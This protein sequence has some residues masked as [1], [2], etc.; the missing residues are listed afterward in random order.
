MAEDVKIVDPD[1]NWEIEGR[2][3]SISAHGA[4]LGH[5]SFVYEDAVSTKGFRKVLKEFRD[6]A[7]QEDE[8]TQDYN[9]QRAEYVRQARDAWRAANPGM[10][11]QN[12]LRTFA[13][14]GLAASRAE[15][16]V[17][18]RTPNYRDWPGVAQ[19]DPR[20]PVQAL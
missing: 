11:G 9:R 19:E 4:F 3:L 2:T 14:G 20:G 17:L 12:H 6:A 10:A 1:G 13:F 7:S 16:P 15:Q 5:R 18:T 8:G